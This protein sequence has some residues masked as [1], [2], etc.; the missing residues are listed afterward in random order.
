MFEHAARHYPDNRLLGWRAKDPMTGSYG[1]FQWMDYKTVH[2]RRKNF[3]AGLRYLHEKIG[4]TDTNYG[5]GLWSPNRPEWQITDLAAVCQGCY[6][7]SI[8]DTLGPTSTEFIVNHALVKTVICSL[9]VRLNYSLPNITG[10]L[11]TFFLID[12]MSLPCSP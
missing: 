9:N 5:I 7:V 8:Y 11:I 10:W 4:V 1:P 6:T 12:S 3:G 2:E